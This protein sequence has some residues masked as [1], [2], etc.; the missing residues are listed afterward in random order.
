M[1]KRSMKAAILGKSKSMYPTGGTNPRTLRA[2]HKL[3]KTVPS[4]KTDEEYEKEI[5]GGYVGKACPTCFVK[6]SKTG[7]C[8]CWR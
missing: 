5:T 3:Y 8:N 4:S 1:A 7:E 6:F 2:I